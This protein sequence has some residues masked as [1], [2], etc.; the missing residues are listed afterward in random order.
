MNLIPHIDKD[1]GAIHLRYCAYGTVLPA[2]HPGTEA[3]CAS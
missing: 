3:L 2:W 1:I